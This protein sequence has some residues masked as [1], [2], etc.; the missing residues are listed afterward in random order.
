[1]TNDPD[2]EQRQNARTHARERADRIRKEREKSNR[3]KTMIDKNTRMEITDVLLMNWDKIQSQRMI[4]SM[5]QLELN[6]DLYKYTS[7][8]SHP[9]LKEFYLVRA[10]YWMAEINAQTDGTM[11]SWPN[12]DNLRGALNQAMGNCYRNGYWVDEIG[13][14]DAVWEAY[15]SGYD[16]PS[17]GK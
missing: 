17:G 2:G 4:I 12:L 11:Q 3:E 6:N 5:E 9:Y 13:Q 16:Y 7:Q 8:K 15:D 1:V 14:A 10:G